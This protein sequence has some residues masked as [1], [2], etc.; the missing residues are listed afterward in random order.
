MHPHIMPVGQPNL[1]FV[2]CKRNAMA[3]IAMSSYRTHIPS[4]Y[5]YMCHFLSCCKVTYF[6][7]KQAIYCSINERFL[8]IDSKRADEIGKRTHFVYQLMFFCV[9]YKQ[10]W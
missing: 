5:F 6:K 4:F 3:R 1:L 10:P 9:C 7:A 2:R 8:T